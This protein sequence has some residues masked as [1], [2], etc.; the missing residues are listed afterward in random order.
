MDNKAKQNKTF[1]DLPAH[2]QDFLLSQESINLN[3]EISQKFAFSDQ[4]RRLYLEILLKI[5]LKEISLDQLT[6]SLG[7]LELGQEKNKELALEI[8]K[9]KILPLSD[10]LK[11]NVLSYI[12]E[13][14]GEIPADEMS[15]LV[16]RKSQGK[17][18]ADQVMKRVE[19]DLGLKLEDNVLRNRFKNIIISFLRNIR[20]PLETTIVLK[21]SPKIGGLGLSQEKVDQ[22]MKLLRQDDK[23]LNQKKFTKEKDSNSHQNFSLDR[24]KIVDPDKSK[25]LIEAPSP[26]EELLRIETRSSRPLLEEEKKEQK[27]E[28]PQ[29]KKVSQE[30]VDLSKQ[31]EKTPLPPEEDL[32]PEKEKMIEDIEEAMKNFTPPISEDSKKGKKTVPTEIKTKEE[33]KTEK[34]IEIE[35]GKKDQ[36]VTSLKNKIEKKEKIREK[37]TT[38]TSKTKNFPKEK[39]ESSS[40][41]FLEKSSGEPEKANRER[42]EGVSSQPRIYGPADQLRSISLIDWRRWGS[43]AEAA[44]KIEDKINLLAED[45]LVKKAEGIKAWKDSEINKLYLKIGEDSINQGQSVEKIIK[46]RQ[47]AGE[48]T[49]TAEEFNTV[50]ELN[51]KLRF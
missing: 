13:L 6:E 43:S 27:N 35:K 31:E 46:K 5:Y 19:R 40:L 20:S 30:S 17:I 32:L 45:S 50:V 42:V 22:V 33:E 49:L 16:K 1:S 44:H 26:S 15:E 48:K 7:G 28:E 2:V 47:E 18:D 12:K 25:K 29:E 41:P 3:K 9:K 4:Q 24:K 36:E 11:I 34:D 39:Q 10:Y 21:R 14:G 8:L 23:G 51:R 38:E 37:K